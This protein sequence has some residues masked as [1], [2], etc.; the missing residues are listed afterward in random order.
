LAIDPITQIHYHYVMTTRY[1]NVTQEIRRLIRQ[2]QWLTGRQIPTEPQLCEQ[3]HVSRTTI[4]QAVQILCAEGLLICRQGLGTFVLNPE[5]SRKP[6]GLSDFSEQV[7]SGQL[8]VRRQ[9]VSINQVVASEQQSRVLREMPGSVLVI[10]SRLDSVDDQ[11]ISIDQC[12]IPQRNADKLTEADFA[13]PLFLFKWEEKQGFKIHRT[14]QTLHTEP[15]SPDD[16]AQLG[17]ASSVW[18]LLLNEL[19]FDVE[20]R[21]AGQIIT[22]YRGDTS[23]LT[24]SVFKHS[25]Q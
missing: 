12:I 9:V 21:V 24:T 4:R 19:F 17:L 3:F 16:C 25:A 8:N 2:G 10:A 22:R 6:I 7:L 13:S 18:M 15:A 1:E 20:G 11:P 5:T 23:K 14:D